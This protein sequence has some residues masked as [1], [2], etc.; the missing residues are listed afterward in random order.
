MKPTVK[1]SVDVLLKLADCLEEQVSLIQ[2]GWLDAEK[3]D[4]ASVYR[5]IRNYRNE[6]DLRQ[7]IQAGYAK[8]EEWNV[9]SR[10]IEVQKVQGNTPKPIRR[11][12]GK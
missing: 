9:F 3:R 2:S 1:G 10:W 7:A 8:I 4:I 5:S 11:G 12:R 6:H